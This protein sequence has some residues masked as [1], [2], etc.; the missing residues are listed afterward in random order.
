MFIIRTC[1]VLGRLIAAPLGNAFK[2]LSNMASL[3][4]A[5]AFPINISALEI[6]LNIVVSSHVI[7]YLLQQDS[8]RVA[9]EGHLYK[10]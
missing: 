10:T 2:F 3:I 4:F 5:C 8:H 1:K 6:A 7:T 9:G